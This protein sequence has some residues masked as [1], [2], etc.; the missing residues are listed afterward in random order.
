MYL[1]LLNPETSVLSDIPDTIQTPPDT[2]QTTPSIEVLYN[3]GHWKKQ[4]VYLSFM[5]FYNILQRDLVFI[6][7]RHPETPSRHHPE[8]IQTPSR[9]HPDT[10][11][12]SPDTIQTPSGKLY[13]YVIQGTIK[14]T[15]GK[16]SVLHRNAFVWGCLDCVS[17]CL[18][19]VWMGYESVWVCIS[20]KSVGKQIILGQD[21]LCLLFRCSVL[22]KIAYAW[23]CLDCVCGVSRWFVWVS[24]RVWMI[25]WGVWLMSWG[26]QMSYNH[27]QL[28]RSTN[29]TWS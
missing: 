12:T 16:F 23:G 10:I 3:I 2:T 24:D 28:N 27:K 15:K 26:V 19:V 13:F 1:V 14:T 11:Q 5:T 22:H 7:P 8:T 9:H 18:D 29:H 17:G 4:L 25:S 20:T 6:H 21:T